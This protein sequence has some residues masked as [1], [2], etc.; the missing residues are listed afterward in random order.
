VVPSDSVTRQLLFFDLDDTLVDHRSAEAD[1]HRETY[2]AHAGLFG[3]VSYEDWLAR[4][5]VSNKALWDAF[6]QGTIDRHHLLRERFAEPLGALGL[7]G[8]RCED[9]SCFYLEAYARQWRLNDGAEEILEE[10]ARYGTVGILSNGLTELQR[11]KVKRFRLERF[12]THVILSEE[13][14]AMKPSRAIFDAAWR[15]AAN[16][17]PVRR[18][19]VG[20]SF[21]TD[22]LGAKNAGW[23]PVLYN[24]ESRPMPAPV[25]FVTRLEDLAPLLQ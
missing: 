24:P 10:A 23:L 25:L 8:S 14:G 5:R 7:D 12:V 4:Y 9:L 11:A 16:G 21:E 1:A 6:G 17:T 18:V 19:Y 13:V 2:E 3:S 15:A 22:V 20:D